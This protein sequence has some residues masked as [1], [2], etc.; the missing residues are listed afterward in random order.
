MPAALRASAGT[1]F[2][3]VMLCPPCCSPHLPGELAVCT[4]SGAVYL[5][6]IETG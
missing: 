3:V 1:P 2:P 4:Q 5:W 6:S